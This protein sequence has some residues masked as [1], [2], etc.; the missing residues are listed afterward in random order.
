MVLRRMKGVVGTQWNSTELCFYESERFWGMA[1][2]LL[3]RGWLVPSTDSSRWGASCEW[4]SRE[5]TI[6]T[7]Y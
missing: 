1:E 4:Y 5:M 6:A 2:V 7:I 3:V